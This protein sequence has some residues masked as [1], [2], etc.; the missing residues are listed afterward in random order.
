MHNTK[1]RW[2]VITFT[3]IAIISF[4]FMWWM[5]S[6]S[7]K[8]S[9]NEIKEQY[10]AIISEQVV[11]EVESSVK[12]GKKLDSF[13]NINSIFNQVGVLLSQEFKPLITNNNGE[14]LYTSFNNE[15]NKNE[16]LNAL[17]QPNVAVKLKSQDQ[18]KNYTTVAQGKYKIMIFPIHDK[19]E[20][21][22][23][24][25]VLMYPA[26]L[27]QGELQVQQNRTLQQS[28]V[29]MAVA[30]ILLLLFFLLFPMETKDTGQGKEKIVAEQIKKR[31]LLYAVPAII[32][33]L[34]ITV[35][36]YT[37]YNQYRQE[38]RGALLE[39]ARGILNYIDNTMTTLH[40]KGVPYDEMYGL[41]EFLADKVNET[42]ILWDVRVN[43]VIYDTGSVLHR[44]SNMSIM[45]PLKSDGGDNYYIEVGISQD[46]L[47]REMR[48]MLL[49]FLGVII[50]AGMMI[51]E[52]M[53]LP[54]IIILRNLAK[55]NGGDA[56]PYRSITVGLRAVT[57]MMFLG[58]YVSLPYSAIMIRQWG[59]SLFGLSTDVT[60][61][62]PVTAELFAM[63]LFSLLFTRIHAF[64]QS[65][66]WIFVSAGLVIFGNLLCTL[67]W[68]PLIL[69]IL[70]MVCGIG[71]AG[72][73]TMINDIISY[74][75]D[76]DER[77][78][79]NITE[80][81]AG[82]LGGITCGG[83]LG[84]VIANSVGVSATFIGN[85][86][87]LVAFIA[88]TILALPWQLLRSNMTRELQNKIRDL[89]AKT[90]KLQTGLGLKGFFQP[91]VWRYLIL[92]TLPLNLG[93]MFIVA[94]VPSYIQKM[95][96]PVLLISYGYLINGL[97]GI[98]LGPLLARYL[99]GKIGRS[100]CIF[101]M[102]VLG[103][104][105][106]VLL[107]ISP[108]IAVILLSTALMGLFDGFGTPVSIDYFIDMP[109]LKDKMNVT[110]SLAILSVLGNAVQMISPLI[111][112]GVL[113]MLDTGVNSI[114]VLAAAY[115]LF[116][117]LFII[118]GRK[119]PKDR[120]IAG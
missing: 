88:F 24:N 37:I 76:N 11:N 81:N 28:L 82:L 3:V 96:L 53:R 57:F 44:E 23:G 74:G 58:A 111:Y 2:L 56:A 69:I 45:T 84:A 22:I 26:S 114:A 78:G 59:V 30:V 4:L 66:T 105:S 97:A 115:L 94:F 20:A 43:N 65:K 32:V 55:T 15:P 25:F 1:R 85:A 7:F 68:S 31:R 62:L 14:V 89:Q 36:S 83:S 101:T 92:V 104:A 38:Y 100:K 52:I 90:K 118:P 67:A 12:Y 119:K 8:S 54:D 19:D 79:R 80:M 60:A 46:Y 42:P 87:I 120:V 99:T 18:N 6:S 113:L 61:S 64:R 110:S 16:Y 103:A 47:D 70:R 13:Y 34:G 91:A 109:E 17:T 95:D 117:V 112:G 27:G 10:Y 40:Q 98:Y 9:Y 39:G 86:L 33:I 63:M 48:N 21:Y 106:M 51:F 29:L 75:Y 5:S 93:L 71:L 108:G 102:L 73:K 116:A 72:L 107:F 50:I 77:R 49:A 35:Q 41:E